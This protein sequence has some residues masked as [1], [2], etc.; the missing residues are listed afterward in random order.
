[1][2]IENSHLNTPSIVS[3]IEK[4]ISPL[5]KKLFSLNEN[6]EKSEDRNFFAS[7]I[8]KLDAKIYIQVKE[9]F[10]RQ[11]KCRKNNIVSLKP[12]CDYLN[13]RRTEKGRKCNDRQRNF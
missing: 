5:V 9:N 1:M 7:S 8:L 4:T 10:L 6:S 12:S 2:K 13:S 11:Q 3:N